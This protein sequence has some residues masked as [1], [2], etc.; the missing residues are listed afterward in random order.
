MNRETFMKELETLL[1]DIS[2]EERKE[3]LEYYESYFEDAGKD[4]ENEVIEELQS[5]EKVAESI[6]A[7][8]RGEDRA[9]YTERGYE[10]EKEEKEKQGISLAKQSASSGKVHLAKEN[11]ER[12]SYEPGSGN[13]YSNKD[14]YQNGYGKQ[15]END[16]GQ[17][18]GYQQKSE[19]KEKKTLYIIIAVIT[20]PIWIGLLIGLFGALFGLLGGLI[21]IVAGIFGAAAGLLFGGVVSVGYGFV[22][23]MGNVPLGLLDMGI[24]FLCLSG[25]GMLLWAGLLLVTKAIPAFV[26]WCIKIVKKIFRRKGE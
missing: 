9:I 14:E 11:T 23:L 2:E 22:T 5:P 16:N 21:G 3:A 18:S 24:G 15:S 12:E 17:Q 6:Q 7:G 1:G 19:D 25:G 8:L 10:E 20:S 4:K 13:Q 26:K